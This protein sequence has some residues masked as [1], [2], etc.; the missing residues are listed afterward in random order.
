L[1]ESRSEFREFRL[2][3]MQFQAGQLRK[4]QQFPE[5]LADI[6]YMRDSRFCIPVALAAV[7]LIAV[8]A[9]A[10][11]KATRFVHRQRDEPLAVILELIH[12]AVTDFEVG[13]DGAALVM[14]S[15]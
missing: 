6:L 9:E 7:R 8:E 3:P 2:R 12:L 5:Q 15:H 4:S 14:S 10:I 1:V 11:V 13:N